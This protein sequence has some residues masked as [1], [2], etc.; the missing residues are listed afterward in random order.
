MGWF[1][2]DKLLSG[3]QRRSVVR[4]ALTTGGVRKGKKAL[5]TS[6]QG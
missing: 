3:M 6:G 2:K 4:P 5:P 1:A